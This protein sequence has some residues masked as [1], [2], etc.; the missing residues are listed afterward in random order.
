MIKFKNENQV[1]DTLNSAEL[2]LGVFQDEKDWFTLE[3]NALMIL[4]I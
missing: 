1:I 3:W 2:W 4:I